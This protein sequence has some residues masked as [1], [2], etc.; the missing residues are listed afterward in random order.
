[1]AGKVYLVRGA[2]TRTFLS[3]A[4]GFPQKKHDDQVD[5]VSGGIKMWPTYGLGQRKKLTQR[6]WA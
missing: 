6:S 1:V 2:W 4:I 5:S 3:E